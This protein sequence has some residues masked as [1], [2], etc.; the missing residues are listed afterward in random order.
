MRYGRP[1]V[2]ERWAGLDAAGDTCEPLRVRVDNLTYCEAAITA[3]EQATGRQL[4]RP[5]P[6]HA[7]CQLR[8]G[9]CQ[10]ADPA[11][12][13]HGRRGAARRPGCGAGWADAALLVAGRRLAARHRHAPLHARRVLA[14]RCLHPADVGAA[15]HG[16]H[17]ARPC[18]LR[19][20]LGA[21]LSS[22]CR[23]GDPGPSPSGPP[24]QSL[25][26]VCGSS[27]PPRPARSDPGR[28]ESP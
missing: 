11:G 25:G 13:I 10:H 15:R 7:G 18:L 12:R 6:P 20:P 5:A 16:G 3:F 4:P 17:A 23:S 26:L 27:R 14:R 9:T 22:P 24:A 28:A 8:K 1:H 2:L 19:H 21:S